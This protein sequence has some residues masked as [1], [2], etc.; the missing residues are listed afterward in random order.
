MPQFTLQDLAER[1][2]GRVV[3]DGARVIT[4][5]KPPL[6]ASGHDITFAFQPKAL[7]ELAVSEAG[8]AVVPEGVEIAGRDLLVHKNPGLALVKIL[9]AFHPEHRPA[10]GIHASAVVDPSVIVGD[11]VYVGPFAVIERGVALSSNCVVHAGT[12]V[13]ADSWIGERTLLHPRVV[14]YQGTVLGRDCV[15][16]SGVVIGA[17]GFGFTRAGGKHLKIPQ[18]GGVVIGDEV[19]IGANSCVDRGTMAPTRI[20]SGTKIDN[21]VQI[22]HNCEIGERVI[23][24]G[25]CAIAGST[26]IENDVTLAGQVGV[27]GH[28]RIGAGSLAAAGTGITSDL[29]AGSRVAGHPP[30]A[31]E[32]WRRAQATLRHLPELRTQVRGMA[33]R[34]KVLEDDGARDGGDDRTGTGDRTGRVEER[35][36]SG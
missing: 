15:I 35:R 1:T 30:L 7:K 8:A 13:G 21:L 24:C 29:A 32:D 28:L 12:H 17:D 19:E 36:G 34:L 18:V 2:G 25:Q 14:L 6:A 22:G 33:K 4:G 11:D 23:V 20:G 10:P 5:A 31:I 16:H 9:Q 27:A 26:I 3:G